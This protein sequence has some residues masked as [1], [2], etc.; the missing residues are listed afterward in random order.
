[1]AIHQGRGLAVADEIATMD[2]VLTAEG[3]VGQW[4]VSVPPGGSTN[5]SYISVEEGDSFAVQQLGT[6][7]WSTATYDEKAKALISATRYL[8][9][10]QW[11]GSRAT[12]TQA[13]AWPRIGAVC[14]EKSYGETVIP[15]EV[16]Q[17]TFWLAELLLNDPNALAGN[18][19]VGAGGQLVPGIN[20]AD[21]KSAR[22]DV[23]ELVWRDAGSGA[24][25]VVNALTALPM[26]V[27]LFGCLCLSPAPGGLNQFRIIR[28]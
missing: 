6:L 4:L 8:D 14:G 15:P 27:N 24:P 5:T 16:K 18:S 12:A 17:G 2:I 25:V 26:L 28:G 9:Q 3:T 1:M 20:N 10:L 21:L 7:K 19:S 11:I 23:M 22:L 13:L